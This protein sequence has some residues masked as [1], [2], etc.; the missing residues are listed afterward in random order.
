MLKTVHDVI[1][2]WR[3]LGVEIGIADPGCTHCEIVARDISAD[4]L[5]NALM[6]HE[7]EILRLLEFERQRGLAVCVG[8]PFNGRRHWEFGRGKTIAIRMDR[9]KWAA[10][11]VG[12][13]NLRAF[14][15]GYA[16][17]E[18]NARRLYLVQPEH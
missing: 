7:P 17:S 18:R 16:T 10:Y 14:F 5:R 3:D 9:G 4:E 2:F 13:D 8:G 6:A 11:Q 12:D 1:G 15:Q